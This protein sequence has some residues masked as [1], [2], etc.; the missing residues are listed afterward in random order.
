MF[1]LLGSVGVDGHQLRS[2]MLR[3]LLAVLLL[4]ARQVVSYQ[5]LID[6][7]WDEPP[8]SAQQNLRSYA[9][10]LRRQL[11]PQYDLATYRSGGYC[12]AV[13][14]EELD[15]EVFTR[16]VSQACE[17]HGQGRLQAAA[18]EL[19]RAL[20]L[21]SGPAGVDAT[22]STMMRLRFQALDQQRLAARELQL[23]TRMQLGEYH[24]VLPELY[25]LT[26]QHALRERP[27]SLLI[28]A[29]YLSG[30]STAALG[31]YQRLR[32]TLRDELGV[33][34]SENLQKLHIAVL[35]DDHATVAG[36]GGELA[37]PCPICT[38]YA[39]HRDHKGES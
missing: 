33:G 4:Q 27:W 6:G 26:A 25:D 11:A 19:S 32:C 12:L 3:G 2:P 39:Y 35:R 15:T 1:R 17:Y 36:Q 16:L 10:Q 38:A 13:K 20:A 7:L 9:T 29:S 22:A 23:E 18:A 21:W 5:Q 14:P 8:T 28:R 34:P 37:R 31:A 30:D 24:A